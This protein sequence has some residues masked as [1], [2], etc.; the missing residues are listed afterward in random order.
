MA[1]EDSKMLLLMR[2]SYARA[3][4]NS[5]FMYTASSRGFHHNFSAT[6]FSAIEVL[7]KA[8]HDFYREKWQKRIER[9]KS[10]L[11]SL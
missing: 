5:F 9:E 7:V 6:N 8:E 1:G 4:S 2:C 10:H 11:T 3:A